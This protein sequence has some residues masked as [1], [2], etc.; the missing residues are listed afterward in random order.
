MSGFVEWEVKT[1]V[2]RRWNILLSTTVCAF[3]ALLSETSVVDLLLRCA[4]LDVDFGTGS[5]FLELG[6]Q[7]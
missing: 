7:E 2:G 1:S 3:L 6:L 4:G 5:R